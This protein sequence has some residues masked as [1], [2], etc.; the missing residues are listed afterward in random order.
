MKKLVIVLVL[1]MIFNSCSNGGDEP[2]YGVYVDHSIYIKYFD[3]N[4]NNLLNGGI[5]ESDINIY[6]KINNE[7]V[8]YFEGNLDYPKGIKIVEIEN[9]KYLI[10]FVSDKVNESNISETK[11]ELSNYIESD[12]FKTEID[13]SHGNSI[14]RKIWLNGMMKWESTERTEK[15]FEIIK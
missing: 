9:E 15:L 10:L 11:I 12:I 7:W 14:I 2:I 5:D 3:E 1:G 8:Y 13:N 4:G 6:R